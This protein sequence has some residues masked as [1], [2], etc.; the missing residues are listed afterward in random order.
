MARRNREGKENRMNLGELIQAL[1]AANPDLV[2]PHGFGNP[3][4]YRGFYDDLAF[5]PRENVTVAAMLA[6]AR[7][8]LGATFHGWKGG[9]YTMAEYTDCWLAVAGCTGE[10]IGP[11]LLRYMLGETGQPS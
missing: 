11:V 3:H 8:A 10:G 1:E 6:D 5:E 7:S 9:E 4:S 2:V